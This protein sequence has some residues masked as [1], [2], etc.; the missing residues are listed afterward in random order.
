MINVS[1]I[2]RCSN[3]GKT[4]SAFLE[5]CPFCKEDEEEQPVV[6]NNSNSKLKYVL[7]GIVI[8]IVIGFIISL[9]PFGR[10]KETDAWICAKDLVESELLYDPS[11]AKFGSQ[12][13]AT[14]VDMGDGK[15]SVT[16]T[17]EAKNAYGTY[18]KKT[19]R[20]TFTLTDGG[21]K[22]GYVT[23]K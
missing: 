13:D 20:A 21:Y 6:E 1:R 4:Y 17:V 11:S 10:S 18:V 12:S 15:W 22:D 5:V 19:F 14:I 2:L 8:A 16:G 3:C 9:L 23:F 7:L